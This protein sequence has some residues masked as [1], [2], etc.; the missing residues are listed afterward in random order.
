[1]TRTTVVIGP[2]LDPA[3]TQPVDSGES[4]DDEVQDEGNEY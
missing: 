1:M 4:E 2:E 3:V